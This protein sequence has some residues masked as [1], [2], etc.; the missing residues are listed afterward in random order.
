[1]TRSSD[2]GTILPNDVSALIVEQTG[3]LNLYL[4][5]HADDEELSTMT[6]LL[7]AVLIR[8]EDPDW[9]SEMISTFEMVDRSADRNG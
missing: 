3:E 2:F 9:V 5:N 7:T 4:A 8:S 6:Q 1:M